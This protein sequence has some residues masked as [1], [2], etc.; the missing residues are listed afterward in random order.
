MLG[1]EQVLGT[2]EASGFIG[3]RGTYPV[4]LFRG[5]ILKISDLKLMVL[6]FNTGYCAPSRFRPNLI[7]HDG[8]GP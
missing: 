4:V 7:A 3:V 2:L 6:L 8:F 1:L 5:W